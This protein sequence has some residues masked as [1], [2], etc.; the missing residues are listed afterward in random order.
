MS[1]SV[2]T[3]LIPQSSCTS[4]CP[5]AAHPRRP[6]GNPTLANDAQIEDPP[7]GVESL[8]RRQVSDR[9]VR[10]PSGCPRSQDVFPRACRKHWSAAAHRHA[11]PR[12]IGEFRHQGSN[13]WPQ[14]QS[15]ARRTLAVRS[16]RSCPA[17]AADR[18]D[19]QVGEPG[20]TGKPT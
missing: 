19:R 14:A 15:L 13:P 5:S 9:S 2:S 16:A 20:R 4:F 18:P 7:A 6:P 1:Y 11:H 12:R 17:P 10:L 8:R 3:F